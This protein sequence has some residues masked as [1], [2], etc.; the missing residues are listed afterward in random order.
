LCTL[1]VVRLIHRKD[2]RL[3]SN[4][5]QRSATGHCFTFKSHS[6]MLQQAQYL[7]VTEKSNWHAKVIPISYNKPSGYQLQGSDIQHV[8]HVSSIP[9]S[10]NRQV[11][12][13][14]KQSLLNTVLH[15]SDKKH[16][17]PHAYYLQGREPLLGTL[18]MKFSLT[19]VNRVLLFICYRRALLSVPLHV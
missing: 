17:P 10:N 15:V 12:I 3:S 9:S 16:K 1:R 19:S 6:F 5:L 11:S 18:P 8:L 4:P 14:Y 13:K 7:S 2:N